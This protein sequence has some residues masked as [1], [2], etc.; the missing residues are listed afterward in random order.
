MTVLVVA[1]A[2]LWALMA[3]ISVLVVLLYRQFGLIY[4]GSKGRVALTGLAVG[5]KAPQ[6]AHLRTAGL[7]FDWT[8]NADVPGRG[9]VAIF[10]QPAC[11][12]CAKLTPQLNV[13]ADRWAHLID[14]IF[15]ERGPLP[16]GPT[17]DVASRT[18]WKYV[19]DPDGDLHAAFD[20]EAGPY[21]FVVDSSRRVLAKGIV[22]NIRNLEAVLSLALADDGTLKREAGERSP[23]RF[24]EADGKPVPVQTAP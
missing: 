7:A 12:L 17:H 21:A 3:L 8:W 16:G 23:S 4:I 18:Q 13:F 19:E 1:V 6:I 20:I 9:T 2:L 14:L 15:V 10:G 11:T 24:E 22:N 5:A